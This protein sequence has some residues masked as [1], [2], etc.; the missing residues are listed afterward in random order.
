MLLYSRMYLFTAAL[1]RFLFLMNSFHRTG[2]SKAKDKIREILG[3]EIAD[4]TKEIWGLD[5]E[6]EINGVYKLSGYPGVR[7]LNLV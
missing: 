6:D 5:Q 3:D 7:I 1:L 4:R 2:Y